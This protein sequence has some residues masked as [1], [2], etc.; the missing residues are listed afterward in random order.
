MLLVP[1]VLFLASSTIAFPAF[2]NAYQSP[3]PNDNRGPC[4]AFNTMANHGFLPRDGSTITFDQIRSVFI[5]Q[6]NIDRGLLD[7]LLDGANSADVGEGKKDSF[8]LVQL[9]TH[10]KIEHDVSLVREDALVGNNF[11]VN[12]NLLNQLISFSSDKKT[13][14]LQ[15]LANFRRQ[16][17]ADCKASNKNLSYSTKQNGIAFGEAAIL[18]LLLSPDHNSAN[19]PI[20]YIKA[21]LGEERLPIE[22]GWTKPT[23][24]LGT[25][26]VGLTT[27]D[28]KWKAG[29]NS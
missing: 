3:G 11:L 25:F 18:F 27:A 26:K 23:K 14:S 21:F 12:Q 5:E 2:G 20:S 4:P 16:R 28:L 17:Y 1:T 22:E 19:V 8:D 9:R 6:Y 7:T 15:D 10:N 24:S 29:F 13:I